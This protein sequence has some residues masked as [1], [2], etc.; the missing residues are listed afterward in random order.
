MKDLTPRKKEIGN[1]LK[2]CRNAIGLTQEQFSEK[3][4]LG[5]G[6]YA[7]I[8]SGQRLF[9]VDTLLRMARVLNVSADY[10]LTGTYNLKNPITEALEKMS[11]KDA[12]RI[13]RIILLFQETADGEQ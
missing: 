9:S 6:S 1:R 7:N 13:E 2:T 10:I 3:V 8:E 12:A 4:E 5:T 11:P